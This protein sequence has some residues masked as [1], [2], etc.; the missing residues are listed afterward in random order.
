MN[1]RVG[2]LPVMERY[3]MKFTVP[4]E[5]VEAI[6]A[7]V[8]PYCSLDSH[9]AASPDGFYQVNSLYFDSPEHILLRNRLGGLP[10]R[11]NMRVRTYGEEPRYPWFLEVKRKAGEIVR[12]YRAR[13]RDADLARILDPAVDPRPFLGASGDAAN[14]DLFRRLAQVY[15]AAPVILTTYRRKA[16]FS[17]CDDYARVTFDIGLRYLAREEYDPLPAEGSF[18]PS[19]LETVFD[20]GANVVLELKCLSRNVPLW[21]VDLVRSFEL[22]RRS[23]SKYSAGMSQVFR[24]YEFDPGMRVSPLAHFGRGGRPG[25]QDGDW[26]SVGG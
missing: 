5:Q 3:E 14:A 18:A 9:S 16:Y 13:V 25:N 26:D 17:V 11:F 10:D 21:M 12:K 24:R 2:P 22:Q 15:N 20:E 8:E 6:S 1:P 23:F 4:W 19:D 7:F